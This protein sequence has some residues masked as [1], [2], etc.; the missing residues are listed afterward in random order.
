MQKQIFFK[1]NY[2]GNMKIYNNA[3]LNT[4]HEGGVI[5]IGNFDG[6]HLGHQKVI[7]DVSTNN[8]TQRHLNIAKNKLRGG[9]HGV[10]HCELDGARARYMA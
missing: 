10:V 2:N 8:Q 6:I 3:N 1:K 7:N 9:W 5:A 4:K